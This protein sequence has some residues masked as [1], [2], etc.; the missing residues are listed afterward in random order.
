MRTIC[1]LTAGVLTLASA[2][3]TQAMTAASFRPEAMKALVAQSWTDGRSTGI[4]G[5]PFKAELTTLQAVVSA[6]M[7]RIQRSVAGDSLSI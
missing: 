3:P 5:L 7:V 4:D 6:I 1:L 2:L